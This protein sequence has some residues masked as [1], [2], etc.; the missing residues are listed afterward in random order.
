TGDFTTALAI[1][2]SNNK[3]WASTRPGPE[4]KGV[5]GI[6]TISPDGNTAE[7]KYEGSRIWN[8]A[9]NDQEIYA[10]SDA[11]LLYSSN[12]GTT[13]DTLDIQGTIVSS[14]NPE[15]FNMDLL[16]VYGVLVADEYLW[17]GTDEG[18]GRIDLNDVG[19]PTWEFYRDTVSGFF[20]YP[21]P[22][23]PYGIEAG[24]ADDDSRLLKFNYMLNEPANV[25]VEIFDFA[26]NLVK[27]VTNSKFRTAGSYSVSDMWNGRNEWNKIVAVGIYYYKISLS[28][29]EVHWGKLAIMP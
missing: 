2:P 10:A 12:D 25:T 4:Y 27:T 26:M 16:P 18:A 20:A 21:V 11:G 5:N 24:G 1:Q 7:K 6:S 13:W 3:L 8:F 22:F 23:S 15:P 29:G 9:F 28:T 19:T 14:Q 17:I